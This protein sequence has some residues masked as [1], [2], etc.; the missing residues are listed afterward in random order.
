MSHSQRIMEL[1]V[2]NLPINQ[3]GNWMKKRCVVLGVTH[4]DILPLLTDERQPAESDCAAYT[5]YCKSNEDL[6]AILHLLVEL[7][8][9]LSVEKHADDS[10]ISGGGQA[11]FRELNLNYNKVSDEAIRANTQ[12]LVD[13]PWIPDKTRTKTSTRS[14]SFGTGHMRHR[15][16]R[17]V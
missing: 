14:I 3:Y 6:F 15:I 1:Q 7:P 4:R 17:R 16:H 12:E 8:A 9:A 10:E 5:A 11:A 13:T 2:G